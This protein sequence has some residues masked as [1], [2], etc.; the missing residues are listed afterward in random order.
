MG[1]RIAY[2]SGSVHLGTTWPPGNLLHRL[3]IEEVCLSLARNILLLV[4]HAIVR[5]GIVSLFSLVELL[6]RGLLAHVIASL[7]VH[8]AKSKVYVMLR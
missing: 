4:S 7:F 6:L 2:N 1:D 5:H 8:G 3:T